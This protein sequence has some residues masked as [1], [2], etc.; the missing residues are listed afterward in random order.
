MSAGRV[1]F[2]ATFHPGQGQGG[3]RFS[4]R[5]EGSGCGLRRFTHTAVPVGQLIRKPRRLGLSNPGS[6]DP[7]G[8]RSRRVLLPTGSHWGRRPDDAGLDDLHDDQPDGHDQVAA[9]DQQTHPANR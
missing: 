8:T 4:G 6:W 5:D 9:Q 7:P 2:P 3:D 1:A